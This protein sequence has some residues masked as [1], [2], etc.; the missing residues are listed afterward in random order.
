MP[1]APV[2]RSIALVARRSQGQ[3]PYSDHNLLAMPKWHYRTLGILGGAMVGA[4]VLDD[5]LMT[6][7]EACQFAKVSRSNL[8]VLMQRGRLVSV[9]L[10][11]SRRIA[12]AG[13]VAFLHTC[14]VQTDGHASN[15]T[16]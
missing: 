4:G 15:N 9:K 7:E 5:G 6:I 3:Q 11:K 1:V 10:G 8:Y 13:L 16:N 14:V 12:K 2:F